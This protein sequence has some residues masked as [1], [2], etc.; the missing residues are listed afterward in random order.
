MAVDEY[1][2][3]LDPTTRI[4]IKL[5]REGEPPTSD[6]IFKP[7]ADR[8]EHLYSITVQEQLEL[9]YCQAPCCRHWQ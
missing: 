4:Q 7:E 6:S 8:G 9:L 2:D 5:P 1:G 3:P